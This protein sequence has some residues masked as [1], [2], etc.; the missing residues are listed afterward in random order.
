MKL[1]LTHHRGF[2]WSNRGGVHVKGYLFDGSGKLH[3]ADSLLDYFKDATDVER[4]RAKLQEAN[5]CFAVAVETGGRTLAAVDPVRS[6]P[7]FYG[8]QGKELVLG[9]DVAA[10]QN[11]L[12]G[13]TIDHVAQEEFL[14]AG[15]TVG[16]ATLDPRVRQIEAG[17]FLVFDQ[18]T[19]Q[20]NAQLYFSHA[21]GDFTKKNEETLIE[22]LDQ[23]TARWARRLIDSVEGRTLVVPLSGGYDSRS[24]ICAL[25]REGYQNVICYSY[26]V[27]ASFEHQSARQVAE[28]LK[29]P[30]YLI[31]YGGGCW[32][33]AF[34]AP[35]ILEYC[36]FAHQKCSIPNIQGFPA[37]E[38]LVREKAIA[39]DAVL[40]PG[41]CGDVLG[42]SFVPF[43][44][45]INRPKTL[46]SEG[47]V[48][49]LLRSR[50]TLRTSPLE[51]ATAH[52]ILERIRASVS[53][54]NTDDISGFCSVVEEWLTRNRWSKF[55][56]NSVRAYEWFGHEWR[57][58]LWDRELIAWW[59]R[60][61]L[62][63]RIQSKFYHRYLFE[64]LFIP[65]GVAI[66]KPL[67]PVHLD[68]VAKR[69]LPEAVIPA[70]KALYRKTLGRLR[71]APM[72]I[73]GFDDVCSL[74]RERFPP[75][76]KIR[77]FS[78][79]NGFVG[80]WCLINNL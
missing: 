74:L 23:L 4:F 28:R 33:R 48:R 31:D 58:P 16:P 73:D 67:S 75:D 79:V 51:P 61:P 54:G 9:D 78:F 25:K 35:P 20:I 42:G 53:Q 22:E 34:D 59:Y 68:N 80:A 47:V 40:V 45:I 44:V 69:W 66:K 17:D 30:F 71:P 18:K 1:L 46:L 50:F 60:I 57:L 12:G 55:I 38:Q 21:H 49:Y 13:G 26:G 15:Y 37:M 7:L 36:R 43:E 76:W 39:A 11:E 24:I 70:V 41:F 56:V 72:D 3:R 10:I 62:Q 19:G 77:D 5:G 64:R 14:R 63:L 29:Y 32:Q 27:P 8:I 2:S 6:I 65:F 52:A